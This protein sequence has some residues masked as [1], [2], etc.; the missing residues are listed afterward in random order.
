[1]NTEKEKAAKKKY[2]KS[3]E[4]RKNIINCI[5]SVII[6]FFFLFPIYWLIQMSFKTDM[7]SF[8]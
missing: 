1:M 6:A 3:K 2:L 4:G 7:E 5:I 8:G